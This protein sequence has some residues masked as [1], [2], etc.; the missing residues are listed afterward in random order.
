MKGAK[1]GCLKR[2]VPLRKGG[3][4]TPTCASLW[5]SPGDPG[6][7]VPDALSDPTVVLSLWDAF[8]SENWDP[9]PESCSGEVAGSTWCNRNWSE[10]DVSGIPRCLGRTR[11]IDETDLSRGF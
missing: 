4:Y 10:Y 8:D 3:V 5:T 11:G 2:C 6:L 9:G 7:P 1:T